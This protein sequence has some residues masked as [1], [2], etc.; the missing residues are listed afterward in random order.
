MS[1]MLPGLTAIEGMSEVGFDC[2]SAMQLLTAS[3]NGGPVPSRLPGE[4]R[5]WFQTTQ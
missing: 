1:T 4:Q 2:A 5:L 3:S